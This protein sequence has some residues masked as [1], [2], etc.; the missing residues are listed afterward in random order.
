[1][2]TKQILMHR[3]IP[4]IQTQM[5]GNLGHHIVFTQEVSLAG[6]IYTQNIVSTLVLSQQT[7]DYYSESVNNVISFTQEAIG[8]KETS[9][10]I[11]Q[12]L[13]FTHSHNY[14]G[15]RLLH[16]LESTHTATFNSNTIVGQ[17]VYI[18]SNNVV[19]LAI[20]NDPTKAHVIGLSISDLLA[21]ETGEY[22]TEGYIERSD[23]TSITG[24]TNLTPGIIYYLDPNTVGK[25]TSDSPYSTTRYVVKIGRAA[26]QRQLDIEIEAPI[27]L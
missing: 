21:G 8:I 11:S 14:G 12:I 9:Q 18:V 4:F 16:C 27:L 22:V 3:R 15:G 7:G 5:P 17:P 24:N 20:A 13:N 1:M 25:L 6:S 26:N 19:D 10:S 2:R 23:W